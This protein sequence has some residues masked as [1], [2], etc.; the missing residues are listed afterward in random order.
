M[1]TLHVV[2]I[3]TVT[4][5]TNETKLIGMRNISYDS[6]INAYYSNNTSNDQFIE[7][8]GFTYKKKS[9]YIG[10]GLVI[11]ICVSEVM[12]HT[13]SFK[14]D[15]CRC[16][17]KPFKD[18]AYYIDITNHL[19]VIGTAGLYSLHSLN[20]NETNIT[21]IIDAYSIATATMN[22]VLLAI[23]FPPPNCLKLNC[24]EMFNGKRQNIVFKRTTLIGILVN[25][26]GIA[27][28]Y[29]FQ[30]ILDWAYRFMIFSIF[31]AIYNTFSYILSAICRMIRKKTG[32]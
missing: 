31:I 32:H 27:I 22:A 14:R 24:V 23:S 10:L 9:F 1:L 3:L 29:G 7:F 28:K 18:V 25:I 21:H 8:L 17:N 5:K 19:V 11:P 15:Y 13:F 6:S 30:N 4:T 2:V 12:M 16:I 20:T 26:I